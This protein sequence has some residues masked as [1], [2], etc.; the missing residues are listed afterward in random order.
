MGGWNRGRVSPEWEERTKNEMKYHLCLT[1]RDIGL[2]GG[3]TQ[4][5]MAKF[6]GASP[7][8]VGQVIRLEVDKVTFSQLFDYL[9]KLAPRSKLLVTTNGV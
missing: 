8:R 2:R 4:A 6:L 3:W 1:I 7:T 9:V 5:E